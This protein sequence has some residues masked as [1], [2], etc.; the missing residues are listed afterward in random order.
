MEVEDWKERRS[1][2]LGARTRA[3]RIN[4]YQGHSACAGTLGMLVNKQLLQVASQADVREMVSGQ[5]AMKE[6]TAQPH[7]QDGRE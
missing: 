2:P 5:P 4:I 7:R 6:I 1:W 3:R